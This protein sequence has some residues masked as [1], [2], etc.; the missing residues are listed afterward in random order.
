MTTIPQQHSDNAFP[1]VLVISTLGTII[2]LAGVMIASLPI[3]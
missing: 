1:Y 2:S 3:A